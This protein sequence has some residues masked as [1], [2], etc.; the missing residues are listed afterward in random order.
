MI[1]TVGIPYAY[2]S[3]NG[4]AKAPPFICFFY[5]N[6]EDLIADDMNYQ[7]ID[8]LYIELYTDEKDFAMEAAVENVL[9]ANHL[10]FYR[11]E[12]VIESEK[13]YEVIFETTVVITQDANTSDIVGEAQ[14][15][16]A[17][18]RR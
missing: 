5:G 1:S 2:R 8:R 6:S 9:N 7:K 4:T 10:P 17:I 13:L 18:L 3:F 12:T 15:D 11:S 14:A 16:Y